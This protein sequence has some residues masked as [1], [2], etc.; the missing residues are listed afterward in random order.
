MAG[1]EDTPE[2][3][4]AVADA[5]AL[6][7]RLNGHAAAPPSSNGADPAVVDAAP[8]LPAVV[9]PRPAY[10]PRRTGWARWAPAAASGLCIGA[11]IVITLW[12]LHPSLLLSNTTTTGGD[13]GAHYAMPLF[14]RN[15]L[16]P[17]LHLT[18]WDP[19]WYDGFPL[20]TYYF[21]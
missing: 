17:H 21:V 18:G 4:V 19:G 12:Q 16:L 20:Y 13:T 15:V 6:D 11:V 2:A 14:L 3:G 7:R 9:A 8:S 10:R 5:A 1:T